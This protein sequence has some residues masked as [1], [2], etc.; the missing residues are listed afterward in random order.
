MIDKTDQYYP[1]PLFSYFN[2][3]SWFEDNK[4]Q[5]QESVVNEDH[6]ERK[7]ISMGTALCKGDR[8]SSLS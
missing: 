5:Q 1:E 4:E 7:V 8:D 2:T 3:K 6:I